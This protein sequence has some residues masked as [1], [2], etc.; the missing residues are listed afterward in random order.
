MLCLGKDYCYLQQPLEQAGGVSIGTVAMAFLQCCT[1]AVLN[2]EQHSLCC[3][4]WCWLV[5]H[6]LGSARRTDLSVPVPIDTLYGTPFPSWM[7]ALFFP[8]TSISLLTSSTLYCLAAITKLLLHLL[9]PLTTGERKF[10]TGACQE[11]PHC[12]NST[13]KETDILS[14]FPKDGKGLCKKH[15]FHQCVKKSKISIF[16]F[17]FCLETIQLR[18]KTQ[19][20]F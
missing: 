10:E 6:Q 11:L 13:S 15:N 5:P 3:L 17:L 2:K 19:L 4:D 8:F 14:L 9:W 18:S 12:G 7:W 1:Q 16:C 20:P